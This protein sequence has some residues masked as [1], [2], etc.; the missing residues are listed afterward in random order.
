MKKTTNNRFKLNNEGIALVY[1]LIAGTVAMVF[2]LML[3]M[4]SYN[5]F[6]Q[7]NGN[8]TDMQLKLAAETFDEALWSE[9]SSG[10]ESSMVK[11]ITERI[12]EDENKLAL[13]PAYEP[14]ELGFIVYDEKMGN[15]YV[16]LTMNYSLSADAGSDTEDDTDDSYIDEESGDP[17]GE[18][19]GEAGPGSPVPDTRGNYDIDTVITVIRGNPPSSGNM[20]NFRIDTAESYTVKNTYT[21]TTTR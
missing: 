4:V 15:F 9:F 13:N 11:Y 1:A 20:N 17:E 19:P 16:Y 14:E 12:T 10:T 8:N 6:A 18:D 3:L 5:L 21:M 2:C 7:V